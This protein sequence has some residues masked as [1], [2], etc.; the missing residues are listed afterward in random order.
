[1]AHDDVV[2]MEPGTLVLATALVSL[3][4]AEKATVE[5]VGVF[6]D[7]WTISA[8]EK[9]LKDY[10]EKQFLQDGILA[11]VAVEFDGVSTEAAD[12][13]TLDVEG[14]EDDS[15]EPDTDPVD[16]DEVAAECC[17]I[18]VDDPCDDC[19]EAVDAPAESDYST[20]ITL[21][22][23]PAETAAV[24]VLTGNLGGD[25]FAGIR[26]AANAVYKT[27]CDLEGGSQSVV[28]ECLNAITGVPEPK[29]DTAFQHVVTAY[30]QVLKQQPEP[31]AAPSK[32]TYAQAYEPQRRVM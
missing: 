25:Y 30:E 2:V 12:F 17:G 29:S 28:I 20:H 6:A 21:K 9:R 3:I 32:F 27:L 14:D 26:V 24:R 15:F 16:E 23:T 5:G 10:L 1:M 7:A 22:L 13:D 18:N 8:A 4:M 31:D 19:P 11:E